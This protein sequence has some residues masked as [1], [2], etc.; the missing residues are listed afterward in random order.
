VDLSAASTVLQPIDLKLV[1]H[2]RREQ[3]EVS[4]DNTCKMIEGRLSCSRPVRTAT[5]TLWVVPEHVA[6]EVGSDKLANAVSD[7]LM[8][9]RTAELPWVQQQSAQR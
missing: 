7:G 3:R 1:R 2:D 6:R 8:T 5:Y 4:I 9:A